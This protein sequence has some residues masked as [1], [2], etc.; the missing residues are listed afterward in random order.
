MRLKELADN[1][2]EQKDTSSSKDKNVSKGKE[3][4]L[5]KSDLSEKIEGVT[6]GH[7]QEMVDEM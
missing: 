1:L 3:V 7:N 6:E 4:L 2:Q 5:D